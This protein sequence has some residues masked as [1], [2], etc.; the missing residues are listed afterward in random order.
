MENYMVQLSFVSCW[1]TPIFLFNRLSFDKDEMVAKALRLIA[2]YKEAGISEERVL[3]KLSSTWEGIQAG[4][5]VCYIF[6]SLVLLS[7]LSLSQS[8]SW[9]P[10]GLSGVC[11]LLCVMHWYEQRVWKCQSNMEFMCRCGKMEAHAPQFQ[12]ASVGHESQAKQSC[13]MLIYS[14]WY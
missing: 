4:K 10:G 13:V 12:L 1:W 11:T 2:L 14:V 8:V 7:L 6:V 5:Y 9:S 3:I